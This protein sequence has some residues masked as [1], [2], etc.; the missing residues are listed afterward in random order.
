MNDFLI[1]EATA[2][3]IWPHIVDPSAWKAGARLVPIGGEPGKIGVR[4]PLAPRP[5]LSGVHVADGH[6]APCGGR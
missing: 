1:I 3:A 2:A 6:L 5:G 4:Y